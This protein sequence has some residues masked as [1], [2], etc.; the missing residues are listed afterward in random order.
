MRN[1]T[2]GHH[3]MNHNLASF[4]LDKNGENPFCTISIQP[5]TYREIDYS[6]M[7]LGDV[8]KFLEMMH[9]RTL[10]N[11]T[12]STIKIDENLIEKFGLTHLIKEDE[13]G[14]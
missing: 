6:K 2:I 11:G 10:P 1:I 3:A 9:T 14:H 5:P 7:T 4:R 12:S 8:I 13:H